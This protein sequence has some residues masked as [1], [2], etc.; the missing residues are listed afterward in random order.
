MY[1]NGIWLILIAFFPAM[2]LSLV[3]PDSPVEDI[4]QGPLQAAAQCCI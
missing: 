1:Y 4:C 3:P 2:L